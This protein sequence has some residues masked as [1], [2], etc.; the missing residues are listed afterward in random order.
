MYRDPQYGAFGVLRCFP[1]SSAAKSFSLLLTQ[2]DKVFF[3][4]PYFVATS[5]RR[6]L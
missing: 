6:V 2:V 3:G 5:S 4:T 1:F